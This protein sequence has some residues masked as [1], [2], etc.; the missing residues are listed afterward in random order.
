MGD[1]PLGQ[2]EIEALLL[3]GGQELSMLLLAADALRRSLVGDLV[4]YV[5]NRNINFTNACTCRCTFCGFARDPGDPGAYLL[6]MEQV[7]ERVRE[8]RAFG[9]TEICLQ[10]GISP[11]VDLD[12][13][14]SLLKVTRDELP[15]VHIHAF[16]PMEIDHVARNAGLSI[17][18][19]LAQLM[20]AGL[21]SMPGTA[22]EILVDRVRRVICPGKIGADRW[23]EVILTAHGLGL[24]TTATMMYGTVETVADRA[25]HLIRIREIQERTSGFTE[26]VPLPFVHGV[27]P[28]SRV[29]CGGPTGADDLRMIAAS[30]LSFGSVLPNIQVSWVKMGIKLAQMGLAFGANDFGGTLMEENISRSAGS[31]S[32]TIIEPERIRRIIRDIGRIPVQRDTVYNHLG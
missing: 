12:Y 17:K 18:Q 2:G 14:H 32:G 8:A 23:E 28:I 9:A 4:T 27:A 26:F 24:P 31:T 21:G 30:R 10:G 29:V 5:V 20:D 6:T 3:A 19:T 7:R 13:F 22:A 16:S 25:R 15:G 11:Q 1:E